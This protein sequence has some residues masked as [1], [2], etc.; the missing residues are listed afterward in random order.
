MTTV[1]S[2]SLVRFA[3][4]AGGYY[5]ASQAGVVFTLGSGPASLFW[6]A[7]GLA[8]AGVL[9]WGKPV[10]PA[11]L[12]G[13][14]LASAVTWGF[15]AA[16][17]IALA[18]TSEALFG[19]WMLRRG[20]AWSNRLDNVPS[21]G[22]FV[23]QGAFLAP[24]PAA[25]IGAGAMALTGAT[26]WQEFWPTAAAWWSGDSIGILAVTPSL[27]AWSSP[28]DPADGIRA[29][30]LE[31]VGLAACFAVGIALIFSPL[32]GYLGK[33]VPNSVLGFPAI[34][35][36]GIRI[37]APGTGLVILGTT[38]GGALGTSLGYGPFVRPD[39]TEVVAYL[40]LYLTG[41]SVT[42]LILAATVSERIEAERA[43]RESRQRLELAIRGANDGLYDMDLDSG[44]V[45]YSPR[46]LELLGFAGHEDELERTAAE[47]ERRFHPHDRAVLMRLRACQRNG[48]PF[49]GEFRLRGRD[50]TYQWYHSRARRQPDLAE[51]A[52]PEGSAVAPR[53]AHFAGFITN[54]TRRRRAQERAARAQDL[55]ESIRRAQSRLLVE[56]NVSVFCEAVLAD[57]LSLTGSEYGF[58]GEV[59][60]DSDGKPY[61]KTLA[62]TNIAWN[63]ETRRL[64][65]ERAPQ[66]MEFHNLKT[67]FGAVL[68]TRQ[69]VIA[70]DAPHD[71]RSGGLPAGHPELRSFLGLPILYG[72]RLVGMVGIANR[73]SGYDFDLI[74]ELEPLVNTCA[75][76]LVSHANQRDRRRAEE[77]R[78]ALELKL[79][80]TQKLESLG[81]LAGGIAHD[82]NNLLTGI[83][84]YADLA[85]ADIPAALAGQLGPVRESIEQ[86]CV[87]TRSAAELTRQM[88]DYSGKGRF[89]VQPIDLAALVREMSQLLDVTITK[90]CCLRHDLAED[91]PAI[92]AD[93]T[94]IRQ[95]IMNLILNAAE[96][97]GDTGGLITL[98]ARPVELDRAQLDECFLDDGL[99]PGKYVL[100][101]VADT[102]CGMTDEVRRRIFDPFFTTKFTG[103]GLGL[104]A[105]LGIVRGHRG[106]IK[107]DSQPGLGTTFQVYFP[108]SNLA[109]GLPASPV[110]PV[111][112]LAGGL[113]LVVDDEPT[114]RELARSMIERLGMRCL[115]AADGIEAL[116]LYALRSDD[117]S[118]V[119]LDL[120]MPRL[121]GEEVFE[122]IRR[123]RPDARVVLTTGYDEQEILERQALAGLAGFLQ[124]P[125]RLYDLQSALCA[126]L[127]P[128]RAPNPSSPTASPGH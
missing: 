100:L 21:V 67:L 28:R 43:L 92:E 95:V 29:S 57:F 42:G 93:P 107:V 104:A 73:P 24:L 40:W 69:P 56:E 126:A 41:S 1:S 27:L 65:E 115:A 89:Q 80:Q 55:L 75:H 77:E 13:A 97:I 46:F 79:L 86:I 23:L 30:R 119:L 50:H 110:A 36:A 53:P 58:L 3:S 98:S 109:S 59:L 6:P 88:L 12:A 82:F 15:A 112:A 61:L 99:G 31:I 22:S 91:L 114:V 48:T 96:A 84:G 7:S 52:G 102:G 90:K 81:I 74:S 4:L 108:A 9:R 120:T 25:L 14:F 85:L 124:K 87:S 105:V 117:I 32:S 5:L 62:I 78:R 122:Q 101:E 68:V 106:S 60:R 116:D 71:S 54:V 76:V 83:L 17:L 2:V 103:R 45:Y 118:V 128:R 11:I 64:Y 19:A 127:A 26:G 18:S 94:Q 47:F 44:M 49:D 34:I 35:W 20:S 33:N 51:A 70:N 121:G 8:L 125:F 72:E 66:G 111:S 39:T 16:C 10:W 37:G 63:D 123:I 38:I 113:V